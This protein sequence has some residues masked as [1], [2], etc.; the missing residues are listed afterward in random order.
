MIKVTKGSKNVFSDLGFAPDEAEDLKLKSTLVAALR[1]M[2]QQHDLGKVDAARL[3]DVKPSDIDDLNAG[4]IESMDQ[5]FLLN[6]LF[7][8]CNHVKPIPVAKKRSKVA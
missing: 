4:R 6:M 7:C 8:A 5:T 3:F 2:I 1:K